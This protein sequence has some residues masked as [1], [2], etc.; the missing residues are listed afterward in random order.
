MFRELLSSRKRSLVNSAIGNL[1]SMVEEAE[2]MFNEASAALLD[3]APQA[4]RGALLCAV[5]SRYIRRVS[6]HLSNVASSVANPL[7]Q[8]GHGEAT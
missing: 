5:A 6:A 3:G 8:L 2:Q 7:D 1:L 4:D